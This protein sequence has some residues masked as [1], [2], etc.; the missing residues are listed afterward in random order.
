MYIS[1]TIY[2]GWDM[3]MQDYKLIIFD[4]CNTIEIEKRSQ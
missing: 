3:K 2:S 4:I 1:T